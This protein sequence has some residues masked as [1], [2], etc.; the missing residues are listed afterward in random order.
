M[1]WWGGVTLNISPAQTTPMTGQVSGHRRTAM[2]ATPPQ[3]PRAAD[4]A[5]PAATEGGTPTRMGQRM[6][7]NDTRSVRGGGGRSP[8]R[9][10]P[11]GRRPASQRGRCTGR[12]RG[13]G[14]PGT[15]GGRWRTP[16]RSNT[17]RLFPHRRWGVPLYGGRR[18]LAGIHP[19]EGAPA[20]AGGLWRLPSSQRWGVPIRGSPGRR[21]LAS[22]LEA[23]RCAV[24]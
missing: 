22:S 12:P 10:R 23:A 21:H 4:A 1:V 20:I 8:G 19:C 15:A 5:R 16:H 3:R 18:R 24:R 9:G 7:N 13:G 17:T 11:G 6:V 14:A 2:E